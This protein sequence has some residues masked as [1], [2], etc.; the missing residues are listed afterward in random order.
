[1][2]TYGFI[3]FDIDTFEFTETHEI[4]ADE[5]AKLATFLLSPL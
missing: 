3:P 5:D 1:M 2:R 4:R